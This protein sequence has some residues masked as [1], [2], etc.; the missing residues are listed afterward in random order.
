MASRGVAVATFRGVSVHRPE[1]HNT[2]LVDADHA[3]FI[4][5]PVSIG[6]GSSSRDNMPSLSRGIGCR[7]DEEARTIV[8]FVSVSQ[9]RELLADVRVSGRVAVV[10]T[11]PSSHRTVQFKGVDASVVPPG[12]GDEM[13]IARYRDGFMEELARL[14]F[15]PVGLRFILDCASD[16]VAAIR[17]SPSAAFVQTPGPLA[18][19]P[20]K[21][22]GA[23]P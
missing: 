23:R 9:S 5:G 7:V 3:G 11:Q 17:F 18:G 2:P 6:I 22:T 1:T 10:F 8:V 16:D 19:T 20:L 14:G 21:P 15:D 4:V 12:E 13:V